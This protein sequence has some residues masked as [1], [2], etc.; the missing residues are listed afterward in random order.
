MRS[1]R[2]MNKGAWAIWA[3]LLVP[4]GLLVMAITGVLA[5]GPLA[6]LKSLS[7]KPTDNFQDLTILKNP[8]GVELVSLISRIPY[9]GD[10]VQTLLPESKYE[11]TILQ[12]HGDCS[13]L[14]YGF[15]YYLESQGIDYFL[16][17]FLARDGFLQ[18]KGHVSMETTF[19]FANK[20]V[21]GI[22]DI[23][24]GGIPLWNDQALTLN[25]LKTG[26]VEEANIQS[27]NP[28]KDDRS[29]Y[30]TNHFLQN[31][32]IGI[33]TSREIASYFHFLTTVYVPLGN[34]TLEKYVYDGLSVI[35]GYYPVVH[36]SREDYRILFQNHQQVKLLSI[37]LL[38]SIRLLVVIIP[39]CLIWAWHL[40]RMRHPSKD[41]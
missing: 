14:S 28:L 13:N 33:M 37:V 24:E 16:V 2:C 17:H 22:V 36:V 25:D 19:R 10:Y 12:G 29:K 26:T 6:F 35:T 9:K 7:I 34:E 8:A 31:A 23:L 21:T 39:C 27:F 38:W 30:Y 40:S 3:S 11:K 20:N 15:A 32:V 5:M 4:P 41:P 18:G 1:D